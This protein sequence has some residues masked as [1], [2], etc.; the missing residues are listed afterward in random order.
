MLLDV[1]ADVSIPVLFIDPDTF[2]S[3]IPDAL[4]VFRIMADDGPVEN[5]NGTASV[6]EGGDISAIETGATTTVT[7]EDHGLS[8][9]AVINIAGADGT[10]DVNGTHQITVVD[11]DNFTF[12]D[13]ATSGT[14]TSGATWTTPGL[15]KLTLDSTIR[16]ALEVGRSYLAIAYGTFSSVQRVVQQAFTVVN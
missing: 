8:T 12:D 6:L 3:A 15:Y 11:A 10:T 14:Y 7:S 13:I 2:A 4:P 1:T 5:G 9:G 16:S